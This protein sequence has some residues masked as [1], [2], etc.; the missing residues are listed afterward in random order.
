MFLPGGASCRSTWI[1]VAVGVLLVSLAFIL[2]QSRHL[3]AEPTP[4][5]TAPMHDPR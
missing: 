3:Q 4:P 1:C 5:K 2:Y